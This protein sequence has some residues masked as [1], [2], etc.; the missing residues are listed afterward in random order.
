MNLHIIT[1]CTRPKNLLTVQESV[2]SNQ[3]KDLN[4]TW[5]V[6]FDTAPLKDIDAE[7]L[8]SISGESTKIHFIKAGDGG[9]LYPQCTELIRE[10]EDQDAWIY[11]LDDDN[12]LHEKFYDKVSEFV[13]EDAKIHVF[14]QYVGGKDFTG[15]Q[16][17]EATFQNTGF[18]KTDI[19]QII[20]KRSLMEDYSFGSNYAADGYFIDAVLKEHIDWFSWHNEILSYY[21]YLEK[22]AKARIP[23]VIYIGPGQPE[24]ISKQYVSY[25][26]SDLDVMY[27]EDDKDIVQH[28][29]E[30]RPDSIVTVGGV[31]Q[32]YPNLASLPIEFRRRWNHISDVDHPVSEIGSAAYMGAM[33][34]MLSQSY[35]N[36]ENTISFVTPIYNTKEKLYKTYQSLVRQTYGNWE[37]VLVNDSS[38][39]GKTL[40][41]AE[42]IASRDPRV[43]VYDFREKSGGIIGEV[44]YRGNVLA[45]GYILAELDHDDVLTPNAA[46][47]LHNAAQKHPECGFFYTDC[48]EWT[49][50]G[51]SLRYDPGFAFSYGNYRSEEYEGRDIWVCNQH[52]INPKTI[53]H[54]VGVP[55]HVRAWRRTTYFEIGGHNRG[56]AIADDYEL[57]IRTFL[58]TK[59][60]RIPKLCYIQYIY[61][62]EGG[63]NTHN[64]ARAD[65]QRRVK[66]IMY[67]YNEQIKQR[68]DELGLEDWAYNNNPN[69]PLHCDS[70]WGDEEQVANIT[71]VEDE[72]VGIPEAAKNVFPHEALKRE[73]W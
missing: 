35:L 10:I 22:P 40:K 2:F 70:K 66:T 62:N 47:D 69:A 27:L 26:A 43:R 48:T 38:D 23:K 13:K 49:E 24:L 21:N 20:F 7:L 46:M 33:N 54:I 3:S 51:E 58:H 44:K 34:N 68:F 57:V 1:R 73:K 15:L 65:I 71:Y 14:S 36:D 30:F 18:Q 5:H 45:R 31:W 4:V 39:G 42:E 63:Q 16:V 56:L 25:E 6:V 29:I 41:I 55:N 9:L 50:D 64:L 59:M 61:N 52:D 37:W 53:R 72:S 11:F 8:S 17:R 19:A 12:I 67:Y 32:D 60:C 28:V